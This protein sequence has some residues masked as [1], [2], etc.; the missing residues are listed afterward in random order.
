M[1]VKLIY[2][3]GISFVAFASLLFLSDQGQGKG[4]PVVSFHKKSTESVDVEPGFYDVVGAKTDRP[5]KEEKIEIANEDAEMEETSQTPPVEAENY[6][7]ELI[8]ARSKLFAEAINESLLLQ[9]IELD[10]SQK[11]QLTSGF[12]D[13]EEY[14]ASQEDVEMIQPDYFGERLQQ[15]FKEVLTPSQ[16]DVL[17]T[18][19]SDVTE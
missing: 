4:A 14:V 15:I 2:T 13:L 3:A 19:T 7:Q 10:D 6:E 18:S 11:K 12:R 1:N 8:V 16:F 5:N 17:T 9:G